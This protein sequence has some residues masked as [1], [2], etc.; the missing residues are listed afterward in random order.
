MSDH[1]QLIDIGANL[2]HESFAADLDAVLERAAAA[3]VA[4]IIVTGADPEGSHNAAAL[5]ARHDNL[6]AT[7]GVHPHHAGMCTE[8]T[9]AELRERGA[10]EGA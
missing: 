2:T 4:D 7:A 1:L 9:I 6:F 5:A 8:D 10:A 3:G